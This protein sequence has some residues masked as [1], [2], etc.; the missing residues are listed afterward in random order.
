MSPDEFDL[1]ST[2]LYLF[3]NKRI[4]Y[5]LSFFSDFPDGGNVRISALL[6]TRM[7]PPSS[8]TRL[9]YRVSTV[10]ISVCW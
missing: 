1:F 6:R 7:T 4:K 2:Y 9:V 8:K 5:K 3:G 10:P